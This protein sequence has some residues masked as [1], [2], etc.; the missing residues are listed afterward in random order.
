MQPGLPLVHPPSP[1]LPP[2]RCPGCAVGWPL[3]PARPSAGPMAGPAEPPTMYTTSSWLLVR[4]LTDRPARF[5]L[6]KFSLR[7][8]IRNS[9]P[10]LSLSSPLF[11]SS[12]LS[13][14]PE[15][16]PPPPPQHPPNPAPPPPPRPPARARAF[17]KQVAGLDH[18]GSWG[19][20][21]TQVPAGCD[22]YAPVTKQRIR[23]GHRHS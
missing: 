2:V 1:P 18:A 16:P 5:G 12:S 22:S 10:L 3:E 13:L 7:K 17:A 4:N 20:W 21:H 9:P 14:F 11:F 6:K 19:I 8:L 15:L 23:H